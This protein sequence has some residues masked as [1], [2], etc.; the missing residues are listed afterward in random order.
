MLVVIKSRPWLVIG[1]TVLILC[2]T[3]ASQAADWLVV[4]SMKYRLMYDD[5]Y[6]LNVSQPIRVSGQILDID[7]NIKYE[8][9]NDV[10][11]FVPKIS[12]RRIKEKQDI[13]NS[14]SGSIDQVP[15]YDRE[16][17]FL[18]LNTVHATKWMDV[19]FDANAIS[20]S[21]ELDPEQFNSFQTLATR[22]RWDASPVFI[23]QL[24]E[25]INLNVGVSY[26]EV[27]YKDA[28]DIRSLNDYTNGNAFLGMTKVISDR[29]NF[30]LSFNGSQLQSDSN[31]FKNI[32]IINR[33]KTT[34]YVLQGDLKYEFSESESLR[35]NLGG[36]RT[37]F[38]NEVLVSNQKTESSN[39]G[40]V[41]DFEYTKTFESNQLR[42]SIGR[43]VTPSGAGLLSQRD[44][45]TLGMTHQLLS[46]LR[47]N[48]ALNATRI[49][50]LLELSAISKINDLPFRVYSS[51]N[52]GLSWSLARNWF[53][54]VA[55]VFRSNNY[56]RPLID[57]ESIARSHS[58]RLIFTYTPRK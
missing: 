45:I 26:S 28:E 12:I 52:V 51:A 33:N 58:G 9:E 21:T 57:G 54:S 19:Q 1:L 29:L 50:D 15:D 2:H 8:S 6:L 41:F 38:A 55:Y 24:S 18:R 27:R 35:F 42:A 44:K 13:A 53:M 10:V 4:P 39:N 56:R 46:E 11:D 30:T 7:A 25:L 36:R 49:D 43:F 20:D 3:T 22:N 37:S 34:T 40:Y 32:D 47:I 48:I 16:D 5:N 17:Y 14:G 31:P 23:F